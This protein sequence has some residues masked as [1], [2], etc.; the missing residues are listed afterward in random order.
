MSTQNW[1]PCEEFGHDPD[2][3]GHCG[4]CGNQVSDHSDAANAAPAPHSSDPDDTIDY[5]ILQ[6]ETLALP[7]L[8]RVEASLQPLANGAHTSATHRAYVQLTS[9]LSIVNSVINGLK[10]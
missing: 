10:D 6:L 4:G 3:N 7:V 8:S 9:A 2:E 1:T 5:A